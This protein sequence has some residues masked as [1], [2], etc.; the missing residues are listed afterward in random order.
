[1]IKK[2]YIKSRNV[3]KVTFVLPK[4][5]LPEGIE[6]ENEYLAGDFNDW[7][8]NAQ[9]MKPNSKGVFQAV[10]ELE[11]GREYQFRY[12][13]NAEHWCNDWDADAY[14]PNELGIDNCVL[15]TPNGI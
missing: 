8:P 3:S 1:M 10:L 7:D 4:V 11:P 15:V 13:I 6:T 12:V 14:F 5:E 2:K 9:P